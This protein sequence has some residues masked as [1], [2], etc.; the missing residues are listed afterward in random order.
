MSFQA[1]DEIMALHKQTAVAA[2]EKAS[3]HFMMLH[4]LLQ[5]EEHKVLESIKDHLMQLLRQAKVDNETLL[6]TGMEYEKK[7]AELKVIAGQ[8]AIKHVSVPQ[9]VHNAFKQLLPM[10]FTF[11]FPK[12]AK[13]P[14]EMHLND[15][16]VECKFN[17]VS[18]EKRDV[19][20]KQPPKINSFNESMLSLAEPHHESFVE[21]IKKRECIEVA[22]RVV[23]IASPWKIFVQYEDDQPKMTKLVAK[24][25][26]EYA[27]RSQL[28]KVQQDEMYLVSDKYQFYRGQV[29]EITDSDHCLVKLIDIGRILKTPLRNMRKMSQELRNIHIKVEECSIFGVKPA[30]DNRWSARTGEMLNEMLLNKPA[31]MYI[32]GSTDDQ[33]LVDFQ[34]IDQYVSAQSAL[35]SLNLAVFDEASKISRELIRDAQLKLVRLTFVL[36]IFNVKSHFVSN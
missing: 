17:F 14:F 35:I 32:V 36:I 4:G 9:V 7:L 25:D 28:Y 23:S 26:K 8:K 11:E 5:R 19:R 29:L 3:N 12:K 15:S 24:C 22:V 31:F 13:D 1:I 2:I 34:C 16:G 33:L 20:L 6:A 10:P 18:T 30:T 27:E 21:D